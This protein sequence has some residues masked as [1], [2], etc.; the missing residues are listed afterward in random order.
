MRAHGFAVD[1]TNR[2]DVE[3]RASYPQWFEDELAASAPN[4]HTAPE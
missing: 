3:M 4:V 2:F 1:V